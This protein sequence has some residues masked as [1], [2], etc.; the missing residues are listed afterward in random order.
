MVREVRVAGKMRSRIRY[1]ERHKRFPEGLENE[2]KYTA[3]WSRG[4]GEIRKSERPG[5]REATRTQ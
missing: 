4:Q 2:S 3:V 5:M 1:G